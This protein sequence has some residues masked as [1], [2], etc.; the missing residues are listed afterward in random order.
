MEIIK[1]S[2]RKITIRIGFLLEDEG[3]AMLKAFNEISRDVEI[4]IIA[5]PICYINDKKI[6]I[7]D[8]FKKSRLNNLEIIAAEL[9][10]M[11]LLISDEKELFGTFAHFTGEK[12]SIIPETAV[13]VDNKYKDICQNFDKHFIKQFEQ[14]K[15]MK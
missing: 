6:D 9:P 12:D 4:R 2:R 8:M 11:K 13:G 7:I 14:L 15:S 3:R 1:K 10:M 5:N